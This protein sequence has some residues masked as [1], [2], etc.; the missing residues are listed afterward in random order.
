MQNS[1]FRVTLYWIE[2]G[3]PPWGILRVIT[4]IIIPGKNPVIPVNTKIYAQNLVRSL[5]LKGAF[6]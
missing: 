6:Y 1:S 5:Q 2:N 3:I 4:L